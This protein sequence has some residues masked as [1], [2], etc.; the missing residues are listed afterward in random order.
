MGWK[1]APATGAAM[2]AAGS[3]QSAPAVERGPQAAKHKD[4]G[5]GRAS[6]LGFANGA[7]MDAAPMISG[8]IAKLTMGEGVRLGKGAQLADEDTREVRA[9]KQT[10]LAEQE[11]RPTPYQLTRDI[12][13]EEVAAAKEYQPE[14]YGASEFAGGLTSAFIPGM[15]GAKIA[16]QAGKV[17]LKMLMKS[18]AMLGG[19]MGLINGFNRSGADL[20]TGD[21]A[22][23]GKV[24]GDMAVS[25]GTG[26]VAGGL[27]PAVG[28]G[29][30]VVGGKAAQ[31]AKVL[32]KAIANGV[33]RP[34]AEAEALRQAGVDNLTVG[35]LNPR[36]VLAQVEET[37]SASSPAVRDMR[38]AAT[39]KWQNETLNQTLAPGAKRVTGGPLRDRVKSVA[40]GYDGPEAY[41][42]ID[43]H[44]V[45]GRWPGLNTG[46]DIAGNYK[47]D[48]LFSAATRDPNIMADNA[49]RESTA[50]WLAN[51]ATKLPKSDGTGIPA[52][53]IQSLRSDIRAE[54]RKRMKGTPSDE[55]VARADMLRNAEGTLTEILEKDLPPDAVAKLR[56]SDKQYRHFSKVA[57]ARRRAHDKPGGF[58]PQDLSNTFRANDEEGPVRDMARAGMEVLSPQIPRTG[59]VNAAIEGMPMP[60]LS[61]GPAAQL[62][63]SKPVKAA[64]LGE[65]AWQKR[66]QQ[67]PDSQSAIVAALR[68]GAE[69]IG[70]HAHSG[71]AFPARV[72]LLPD[73]GLSLPGVANT[74]DEEKQKMLARALRR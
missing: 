29:V 1:D 16:A 74:E 36:S 13:K 30:S 25:G 50:E 5:A 15:G 17:P 8:L 44:M 39:A 72:S 32:K 20:T 51:K 46:E 48:G 14:A 28:R 3:W 60:K 61:L 68:G 6:V 52:E 71:R 66:L 9:A 23:Y 31:G 42:A 47:A 65:A 70:R 33:L 18:G 34:T 37:A 19:K 27:L 43:G 22:E 67:A 58:T 11:A 54:I 55:S 45:K 7:T 57:E 12:A 69:K 56:A 49:T 24:L 53:A 59:W 38:Q 62:M 40:A 35:Q 2:G 73:Y 21:L 41:G 64:L 10:A 63:N 4:P 26:M